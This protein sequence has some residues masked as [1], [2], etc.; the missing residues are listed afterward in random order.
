M[1]LHR[2]NTGCNT[3]PAGG[4]TESAQK[5]SDGAESDAEFD[6]NEELL[7][8]VENAFRA[9]PSLGDVL[10]DCP[11][12]EEVFRQDEKRSAAILG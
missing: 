1:E 10:F 6:E 3:T 2:G 4:K 5:E 7:M 11:C 9:C 8:R 12:S